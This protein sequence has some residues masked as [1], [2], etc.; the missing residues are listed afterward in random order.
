MYDTFA[1]QSRIEQSK[2]WKAHLLAKLGQRVYSS[3]D[4]S[5]MEEI[6][7]LG[8]PFPVHGLLP[9]GTVHKN[10]QLYMTKNNH[11]KPHHVR[12]KAKYK[13]QGSIA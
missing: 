4:S 8:H 10:T 2:V 5:Q 6:R 7:E 13:Q 3:A 12:E 9:S 1:F 11:F